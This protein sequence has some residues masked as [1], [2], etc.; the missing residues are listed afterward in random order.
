MD[1]HT[2]TFDGAISHRTR[3]LSLMIPKLKSE[4]TCELRIDKEGDQST[5]DICF[6]VK[7][8][9]RSHGFMFDL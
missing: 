3:E 6:I 7:M 8:F 2:H 9:V 5:G 4:L 1:N